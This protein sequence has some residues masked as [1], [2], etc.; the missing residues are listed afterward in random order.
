[1]QGAGSLGCPGGVLR[2]VVLGK[3]NSRFLAPELPA[4]Y[5]SIAQI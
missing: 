4:S 2:K 3:G 5:I 1:M